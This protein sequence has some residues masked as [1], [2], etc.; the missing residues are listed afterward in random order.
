[1]V[2]PDPAGD[3]I[4]ASRLLDTNV[5]SFLFRCSLLG[6]PY[7]LGTISKAELSGNELAQRSPETITAG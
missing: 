1:M 2:A 6:I 3:L 4:V 5:F 7:Q